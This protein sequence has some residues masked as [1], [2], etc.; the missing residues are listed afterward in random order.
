MMCAKHFKT[1]KQSEEKWF[2][3]H[4]SAATEAELKLI[5]FVCFMADVTYT[6]GPVTGVSFSLIPRT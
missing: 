6:H 1:L 5:L 3:M 4:Q 2:Y